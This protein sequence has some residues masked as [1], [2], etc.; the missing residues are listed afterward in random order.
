MFSRA[1][2]SF[3]MNTDVPDARAQLAS[4][5]LQRTRAEFRSVMDPSL[6]D[7]DVF[8]RSVTFRWLTSH[9]TP[10]ALATTAL[11]AA[12]IRL[13]FGRLI[14]SVLLARRR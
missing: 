13:P 4:L 8:P 3:T 11:T 9:L 7:E 10:R 5:T 14:S 2:A 1:S 12:V 6:L